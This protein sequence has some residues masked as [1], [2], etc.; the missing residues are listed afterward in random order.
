MIEVFSGDQ[1]ASIFTCNKVIAALL[2]V[3]DIVQKIVLTYIVL[4]QI[5][6][7][8]IMYILIDAQKEKKPEELL[9]EHNAENIK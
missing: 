1:Y 4:F 6:E 5:V 7:F 9:Y 8:Y 3:V 2:H